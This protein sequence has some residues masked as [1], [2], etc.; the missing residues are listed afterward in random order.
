MKTTRRRRPDSAP[1]AQDPL[2]RVA[3][4]ISQR[5]R[6]AAQRVPPWTAAASPPPR[7]G[8][9]FDS[10]EFSQHNARVQAWQPSFQSP[11]GSRSALRDIRKRK[12]ALLEAEARH[13][14]DCDI[15]SK[16]LQRQ[17]AE[18]QQLRVMGLLAVRKAATEAAKK[19]RDL[20][21]VQQKQNVKL[22]ER[23]RARDIRM[24]EKRRAKAEQMTEAAQEELNATREE[25]DSVLMQKKKRVESDSKEIA[26]LVTASA[27]VTALSRVAL[28]SKEAS[29][30]ASHVAMERMKEYTA[31]MDR[32]MTR[33]HNTQKVQRER[34]QSELRASEA[35]CKAAEAETEKVRREIEQ[36]AQDWRAQVEAEYDKN[37]REV[38][39][40][41]KE[42]Q[43]RLEARLARAEEKL[44][45]RTTVTNALVDGVISSA[46]NMQ[47]KVTAQMGYNGN[48]KKK[49]K[50]RNNQADDKET[51][52]RSVTQKT[53]TMTVMSSLTATTPAS[54]TVALIS[55]PTEEDSASKTPTPARTTATSTL[56]HD[57]HASMDASELISADTTTPSIDTDTTIPTL[58]SI[59]TTIE[60]LDP[61]QNTTA[62]FS[63]TNRDNNENATNRDGKDSATA[64]SQTVQLGLL[65]LKLEEARDELAA[66]RRTSSRRIEMLQNMHAKEMFAQLSQHN[67]SLSRAISSGARALALAK[68]NHESQ[69]SA[70]RQAHQSDLA[71]EQLKRQV[72]EI[73]AGK[74]AALLV[75]QRCWRGALARFTVFRLARR[76]RD[77]DTI[78]RPR[79]NAAEIVQ[80]VWRGRLG[81]LRFERKRHKR[82]YKTIHNGQKRIARGWREHK[83]YRDTIGQ[84]RAVALRARRERR[85]QG[86]QKNKDEKKDKQTE[87]WSTNQK[88]SGSG[89]WQTTSLEV[90]ADD[91][92]T[93]SSVTGKSASSPGKPTPYASP[94]VN[95]SSN[96]LMRFVHEDKIAKIE[97]LVRQDASLVHWRDDNG[98]TALFYARST[99]MVDFLGA[100]GADLNA[101]DHDGMTPLTHAVL[102]QRESVC[103]L[104]IML[105][106]AVRTMSARLNS[107]CGDGASPLHCAAHV[108]NEDIVRVL[109][110]SGADPNSVARSHGWTPLFEAVHAG[111]GRVVAKEILA[112]QARRGEDG[113]AQHSVAG[114]AATVSA[115]AVSIVELLLHHGG[116]PDT[117][118]GR[119]NTPLLLAIRNRNRAI[120]RLLLDHGA[121]PG[122]PGVQLGKGGTETFDMLAQEKL[123]PLYVSV[124]LE[125]PEL[126][127]LLLSF[128]ADPDVQSN[129][130]LV[131][132]HIASKL[133][134]MDIA[135]MLLDAHCDLSAVDSHGNS[136]LHI[137]IANRHVLFSHTLLRW[138]R[139]LIKTLAKTGSKRRISLRLTHRNE[140]GDTA[141]DV[142]TKVGLGRIFDED[143]DP[144]HEDNN[145]QTEFDKTGLT[146]V[147]RREADDNDDDC[148]SNVNEEKVE[149]SGRKSDGAETSDDYN[150]SDEEEVVTVKSANIDELLVLPEYTVVPEKI[151]G[152]K[153]VSWGAKTFDD[154]KHGKGSSDDSKS[155]HYGI[156]V[157]SELES[158][159]AAVQKAAEEGLETYYHDPE[160]VTFVDPKSGCPYYYNTITKVTQWE[161]P[162]VLQ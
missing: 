158:S 69:I 57:Y 140:D 78:D 105:G 119:G 111:I 118:D 110:A 35:R 41:H 139:Q 20:M 121:A 92:P 11:S 147:D 131:P 64:E 42:A 138:N 94:P 120:V 23:K 134:N 87:D 82:Q 98:K 85:N 135:R 21:S 1:S 77:L 9:L 40:R 112:E 47:T 123:P 100:C 7:R 157:H 43:S 72:A 37:L 58:A 122:M 53:A 116:R 50:K 79:R 68:Q 67:E 113:E 151:L 48:S 34:M 127:S 155:K 31:D 81:R 29:L 144:S 136:A 160:W 104:L 75:L 60:S 28:K 153:K 44:M 18:S 30:K 130:G 73:R 49:N 96:E 156:R 128:G 63:A 143:Y 88:S 56:S 5:K 17:C 115:R 141:F 71:D 24:A 27:S 114:D 89:L 38:D 61:G 66:C 59:S 46:Q 162:Q 97:T 124:L 129:H 99:G 52:A 45:A 137:S 22:L 3:A 32:E 54:T 84:R 93:P 62:N 152:S 65:Q 95:V 161:L 108:L 26:R 148:G 12:Q 132:L 13:K 145:G 4:I 150:S 117:H 55:E 125:E 106:A 126:V 83:N 149:A 80:R 33:L 6:E 2:D 16:A 107:P 8:P 14:H 101:R 103:R 102:Q 70:L 142:A 51:T 15:L 109:L 133:G 86:H 10:E 25:L 91:S 19:T 90:K 159:L 74:D 154:E 39:R 36:A 76:V 146:S